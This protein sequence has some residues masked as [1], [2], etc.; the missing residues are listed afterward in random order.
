MLANQPLNAT[1]RAS[2][3]GEVLAKRKLGLLLANGSGAGCHHLELASIFTGMLEADRFAA[4][5]DMILAARA[6]SGHDMRAAAM[7]TT[8]ASPSVVTFQQ[9]VSA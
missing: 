4:M 6:L 9:L 7:Y 5:R 2:K 3:K 8:G 1:V